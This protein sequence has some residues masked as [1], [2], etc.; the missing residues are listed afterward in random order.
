MDTNNADIK[1]VSF[2]EKDGVIHEKID[3][4]INDPGNWN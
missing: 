3:I 1:V 4:T 2:E